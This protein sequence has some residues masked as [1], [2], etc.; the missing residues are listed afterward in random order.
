M[1]RISMGVALLAAVAIGALPAIAQ[2]QM[3][4]QD[5]KIYWEPHGHPPGAYLVP[6]FDFHFFVIPAE[7]ANAIDCS[8]LSKPTELPTGYAL[9][10]V[11][12]P[13]IGNVI[14]LC[15]PG[16]GMHSL[17]QSEIESEDTFTGAMVIGYYANDP[18][19]YEPMITKELLQRRESFSVPMPSV[20]GVAAGVTLPTT[21]EGVYDAEADAYRFVFTGFPD[22]N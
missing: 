2:E 1:R 20:A 19:F 18:I 22:A 10:D 15:V 6:H 17:L 13:E 3:G 14:G 5:L 16:M 4:V 8:N 9:P 21:F 7:E 12:I 11:D